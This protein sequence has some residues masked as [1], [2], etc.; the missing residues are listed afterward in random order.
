MCYQ[1]R[2]SVK[3]DSLALGGYKLENRRLQVS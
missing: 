3:L 2:K 1:K